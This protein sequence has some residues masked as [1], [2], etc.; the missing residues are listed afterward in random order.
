MGLSP[1]WTRS[2]LLT[3]PIE[4]DPGVCPLVVT[5]GSIITPAELMLSNNKNG[6]I[7]LFLHLVIQKAFIE[8]L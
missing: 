7:I 2:Q 6:N 8:H 5:A 4:L 3:G 1:L